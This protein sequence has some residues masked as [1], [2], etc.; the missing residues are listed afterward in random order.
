MSVAKELRQDKVN[1]GK[2]KKPPAAARSRIFTYHMTE[3]Q[4]KE[5]LTTGYSIGEVLT[6]MNEWVRMG[7]QLRMGMSGD[8]TST[9]CMIREQTQDWQQSRAVS[10][11]H[12]DLSKAI[13]GLWWY[14]SRVNPDWPDIPLNQDDSDDPF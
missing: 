4:R 2:G 13:A 8:S 7:Y 5:I 11:F 9:F 14:L 10:F 6:D 1:R 12:S 3:S